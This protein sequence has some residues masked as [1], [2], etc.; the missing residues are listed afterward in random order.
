MNRKL[1]VIRALH[2]PAIFV[3]AAIAVSAMVG[4][5]AK[6]GNDGAQGLPGSTSPSDSNLQPSQDLP[7]V[8]IT[9]LG[10]SGASRAGGQ[11]QVGD[12]MAVNFTVKR[13]DGTDLPLSELTFGETHFSGPTFNYQRVLTRA[14][15]LI[16]KSVNN[17]D[18]SY[19]YSFLPIPATYA[20]PP[21]YQGRFTT[22]V[23]AGEPLLSG[24]YTI[25][26]IAYKNYTV[27]NEVVKDVSNVSQDVLFGTATTLQPREV[28][29]QQ[30]CDQC[31]VDIAWHNRGL[32]GGGRRTSVKLC[33]TCHTAGAGDFNDPS[34]AGGSPDVTV[35]FKVLIHKI[36]NGAHLPSVLGVG[37]DASGNRV[38]DVTP[39]PNIS[40]SDELEIHDFSDVNFPVMPSA[41]VSYLYDT[42]GT[43]YLGAAGNGPMPKNVGFSALTASHKLQ[44]D[45]IRTGVVAC[46]KCHGTPSPSTLGFAPDAATRVIHY[47]APAQGNLAYIQPSRSACGS[48]HDDVDWTKPYVKNGATMPIQVN[49]SQCV[50]C[51]VGTG[52]QLDSVVAHT[53]P[54]SSP[55][56][57]TGVNVTIT[58]VSGGTG[59]GGNFQP[60]DPIVTTFGVTNDAAVDLNL[61]GLTRFQ[62]IVTGPTSNTQWVLSNINALDFAFRKS[63]PFTGDGTIS[64]PAV[65]V[66]TPP[67]TVAVVFTSGTTFDMIG[68]VDPPLTGQAIGAGSGS[69]A[70][71]NYGGVGFT[72]TQGAT[73]FASGDRWYLEVIPTAA[74]YSMSVPTD[75]TFE[76][77]G[78]ATGGADVFTVANKPLYWGR[79][80]VFERTAVSAGTTIGSTVT[81]VF[82]RFVEVNAASLVTSGIAGANI[83]VGDKIVLD[84]GLPTE[85]YLEL[86][87]IET[88]DDTTGAD[89]GTSDRVWF[90]T[91]MRYTHEAGAALQEVTLTSVR[92][93][94][95]YDVTN[96]ALGEITLVAGQLAASN[97]VVVSYRSVGRFGSYRAPGDTLQ[98]VYPAAP[99]DSDD[100]GITLGDWKGLS[101]VSGTYTVGIWANRDFTVT[102]LGTLTTTEVWNNFTSPNTTYRMI[103]PP[104]TSLFLF[105][106]ATQEAPRALITSGENCNACHGDLQ[107]HGYGRRGLETCLLCHSIPG[108]EDGPRYTFNSYSPSFIP[109][110]PGVT[111]DFR[112]LLHKTH[113]GKD[114]T[115]ASGYEAIGVFLGTP[116]PFTVDKMASPVMREGVKNCEKCHGLADGGLAVQAYDV[117]AERS[118]PTQQTEPLRRWRSVCSSCHDSDDVD[119]HAALMTY[120]GQ[121][122]CG[123]CH[124]QAGATEFTGVR[125]KNH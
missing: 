85:E 53:H 47:P 64:P 66:G 48:C 25:A 52:N 20:N 8:V 58:S 40:V 71:V 22:D 4:G 92:E 61:N 93:G 121:E 33:M 32:P 2:V 100:I 19:T 99:A 50:L 45:K 77:I 108:A 65:G 90:K 86:G 38:Y 1:G 98:A 62:M 23:L 111:M 125:H 84:A 112:T 96:A 94:T 87:R 34:V 11:F 118:H 55:V 16:R 68:S 42:A 67:Q 95:G 59:P 3:T 51:H 79:Q 102:P 43:T 44:D 26:L 13:N 106:S 63:T 76:R 75:I 18:G 29:T 5:C 36:H 82:E 116:Y 17:A 72:I 110:T 15:D 101:F 114:L 69:T 39:K 115:K 74:S 14:T 109:P 124:A 122:S 7:G 88:T 78:A 73:Q 80:V 70:S 49:D 12:V 105:G 35:D 97:P 54:Y 113:M 9:V 60:G 81:R 89:L 28:V 37:V 30:S 27:G 6:N 31:H 46:G 103:S 10:V 117:P 57:N 91:P 123:T 56:L 41:Y 24:T 107:F 21:N 83:G 119:A 104:A 120:N